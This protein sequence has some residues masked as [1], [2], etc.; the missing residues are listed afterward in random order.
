MNSK[1]YAFLSVS[2]SLLFLLSGE[3]AA[4]KMPPPHPTTPSPELVVRMPFTANSRVEAPTVASSPIPSKSNLE[5]MTREQTN[6][7]SYISNKFNVDSDSAS[8]V[9]HHAFQV[10]DETGLHPHLILAIAAVESSFD[11]DAK[12]KGG[13][14]LMQ[15]QASAHKEEVKAIGGIR[16]LF[17]VRKNLRMGADILCLYLGKVNNNLRKAL[18]RYNGSSKST[19]TYPDKVLREKAKLDIAA[20]TSPSKD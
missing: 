7:Q 19:S 8:E 11:P 5:L 16:A 6:L 18:L 1:N 3:G 13:M 2:T 9:V 4:F 10:S 12:N 17:D 14:G 20:N 15:I